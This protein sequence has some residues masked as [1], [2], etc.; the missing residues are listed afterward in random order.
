[1]EV[2]YCQAIVWCS[3]TVC[4]YKLYTVIVTRHLFCNLI[5]YASIYSKFSFTSVIFESCVY[6]MREINFFIHLFIHK[7]AS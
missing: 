3:C 4:R 6:T 7:S 1:M 2:I 5:S